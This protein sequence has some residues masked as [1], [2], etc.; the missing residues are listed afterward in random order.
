MKKINFWEYKK[1]YK[2]LKTKGLINKI[3]N[4]LYS[5]EIFYGKKLNEFEKK[6]L[7]F[8]NSKYGIAVK[9]GTDALI[10]ALIASGIKP[11]DE[12]ITV[13]LTA[14][15]TV[16]AIVSVGAKPVFVDV[17][18]K[19]LINISK[20]EKK[21]SKKTKAIIPVHLYGNTCE[22]KSIISISKKY[23]LKIIE[24]CA[25]SLVAIIIKK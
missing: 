13:S 20:I 25:Q 1:E 9:T 8:N 21:I 22:M 14:I 15:P 3:D 2:Y 12:V 6:F 10:V 11:G 4:S 16:S 5:G 23:K 18:D 7:K 19:C 24:D 17:N